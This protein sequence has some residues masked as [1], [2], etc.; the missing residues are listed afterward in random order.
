M[1]FYILVGHQLGWVVSSLNHR[2]ISLH[3]L[4]CFYLPMYLTDVIINLCICIC[5]C[6]CICAHE[7]EYVDMYICSHF[8]NTQKRTLGSLLSL[9]AILFPWV[10][11][12][13]S[14]TVTYTVH[15]LNK[16][17]RNTQISSP[18]DWITTMWTHFKQISD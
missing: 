14:G 2:T 5:L 1:D 11:S 3:P 13:A 6:A 10:R 18:E 8:C 16:W 12:S 15:S 4:N 7:R 17:K 9:F